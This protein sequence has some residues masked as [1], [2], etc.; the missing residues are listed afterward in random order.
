[1]LMPGVDDAV[2]QHVDGTPGVELFGEP[3]KERCSGRRR[4]I[5]VG[6]QHLGPLLRL[7]LLDEGEQ[8]DHVETYPGVEVARRRAQLPLA[9]AAVVAQP[10]RD[11]GLESCLVGFHAV[12]SSGRPRSPG[13]SEVNR[14]RNGEYR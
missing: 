6:L 12:A 2:T 11:V 9:V 3:I 13:S 10:R 1:L 4:V 5:G 8:L 14:F 7:S